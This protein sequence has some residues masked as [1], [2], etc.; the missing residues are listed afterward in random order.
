LKSVKADD[1]QRRGWLFVAEVAIGVF[2]EGG[3]EVNVVDVGE[4]AEPGEDVGE[5][6][7]FVGVVVAG[8]GGGEFADFFDEPEEGSGGAALSVALFVLVADELLKFFDSHKRGAFVVELVSVVSYHL[9]R[10]A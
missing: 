4:G 5:F 1:W 3:F 2:F 7:D 9:R 8:E 10:K 6:F